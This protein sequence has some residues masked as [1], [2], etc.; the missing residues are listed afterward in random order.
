[1]R[2]LAWEAWACAG[3]FLA[4]TLRLDLRVRNVTALVRDVCVGVAYNLGL[5]ARDSAFVMLMRELHDET[6]RDEV[7][8]SQ[9][10][11]GREPE[12]PRNSGHW[13]PERVRRD[14]AQAAPPP[15]PVGAPA[16]DDVAPRAAAQ[17]ESGG[18]LPG[19]QAAALPPA[20]W[21]PPAHA[22]QARVLEAAS[23]T[24]TTVDA[25][26]PGDVRPRERSVPVD[27][28]APRCACGLTAGARVS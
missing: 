26:R 24:L 19:T 15:V 2:R 3:V 4:I 28:E 23:P 11:S 16:N 17:A 13:V 25:S 22:G 6:R 12:A 18:G 8:Q 20:R 1:M 7:L 21:G 10:S 5:A 27:A 14:S 9:R